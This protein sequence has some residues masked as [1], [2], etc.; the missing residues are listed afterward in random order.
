MAETII[1]KALLS[2]AERL[3]EIYDH[4]V[5][6]TAITFEYETPIVEEFCNRIKEISLRYPFFVLECDGVIRGYA[7]ASSFKERAAYDWSCETT[8]YIDRHYRKCGYGKMLYEALE[9]ALKNMGIL[10]LYACV[11]YTKAEDDYLNNNSA[12]FHKHLGFER[13]GYFKM[14]GYKFGRWYDMIWMEKIIGSHKNDQPPV[15]PYSKRKDKPW[16]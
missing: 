1:R 7:Y 13:V 9:I 5:K 6:N 3:L 8:V 14:C 12:E 15:I 10:N 11:A 16:K 2:D 4:Y